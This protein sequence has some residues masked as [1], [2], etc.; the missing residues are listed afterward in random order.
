MPFLKDDEHILLMNSNQRMFKIWATDFV[1]VPTLEDRIALREMGI[2]TAFEYPNWSYCEPTQGMYE[3]SWFDNII[4]LNRKAGMKTIFTVCETGKPAW[5][6]DE[7]F[8]KQADGKIDRAYLSI[9]NDEAKEHTKKYYDVLLDEYSADDVLFIFGEYSDGEAALPVAPSFYDVAAL[10][11]YKA[12]YGT[13][14]L[15]DINKA[16]T[17]L[18]V[19]ENV[20]KHF[21]YLA[22][23]FYPQ[24][25][26][27]WNM[28]QLLMNRWSP[29]TGNFAQKEILRTFR[30]LYPDL[31]LVLL[32]YTYYDSAHGNWNDMYV[33]ELQSEF[34]CDV[35]VEAHFCDGLAETTP[36]SIERKFRG[37]IICPTHPQSGK[38]SLTP[39]MMMQIKAACDL[40][41]NK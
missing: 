31:N 10:E 17:G 34:D 14:E 18:W 5:M 20:V 38:K 33:K 32:Q 29:A 11:S 23:I 9:W 22:D 28:Q 3:L 35:I 13:S 24:H 21:L 30:E 36:K 27:L 7:W 12:K 25:K 1:Y 16:D 41:R 19:R 2:Q 6:P 26:E 8:G 4:S 39:S 15:P 37:Q 40:W